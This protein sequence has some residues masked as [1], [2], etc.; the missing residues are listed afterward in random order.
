[1]DEYE[2]QDEGDVYEYLDEEEYK[3]LVDSRRQREDFVV[4]DGQ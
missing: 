3:K 4:D 2:V 1:M